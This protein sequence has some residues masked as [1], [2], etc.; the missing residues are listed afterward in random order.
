MSFLGRKKKRE[1]KVKLN[2]YLYISGLYICNFYLDVTFYVILVVKLNEESNILRFIGMKKI[3]NNDISIRYVRG[4]LRGYCKSYWGMCTMIEKQE[5][6]EE[7]RSL[8]CS[9]L[10]V[11]CHVAF[12]TLIEAAIPVTSS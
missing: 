5:S 8:S 9:V 1:R 7:T 3:I 12:I 4:F 6:T 2:S 11:T 10:M